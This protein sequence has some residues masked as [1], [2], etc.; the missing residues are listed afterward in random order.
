MPVYIIREGR[1]I[2][3]PNADVAKMA[4]DGKKIHII[5]QDV[6]IGNFPAYNVAYYGIELP[7][8]YQKQYEDQL[9]WDALTPEERSERTAKA[10]ALRKGLAPPPAQASET[11]KP[12]QE[13]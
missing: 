1:V 8:I 10:Q 9:A 5:R 6:I 13:K 7:P 11:P 12:G 2:H 3:F 4:A